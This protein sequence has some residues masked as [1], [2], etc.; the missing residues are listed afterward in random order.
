MYQPI[1]LANFPRK[2]LLAFARTT[3]V[4]VRP[5]S[6]ALDRYRGKTL[7]ICEVKNVIFPVGK[8]FP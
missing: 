1:E 5:Q 4:T 8:R 3:M 7:R 6:A 2:R